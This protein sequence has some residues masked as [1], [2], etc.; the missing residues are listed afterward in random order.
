MI[1]MNIKPYKFLCDS[2]V[3]CSIW[4]KPYNY[5]GCWIASVTENVQFFWI[6]IY[7]HWIINVTGHMWQS[8]P[9]LPCMIVGSSVLRKRKFTKFCRCTIICNKVW[10]L[11]EI[12]K[13][14]FDNTENC[15]GN[16]EKEKHQKREIR[17]ARREYYRCRSAALRADEVA[18][19][20]SDISIF[21]RYVLILITA[22]LIFSMYGWSKYSIIAHTMCTLENSVDSI[23]I[24]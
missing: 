16:E 2:K 18:A 24:H 10:V 20:T 12:E 4:N 5:Y 15:I 14:C 1:K 8:F 21:T 13:H 9:E 7:S 3:L 17:L 22:Q 19:T 6:A 23:A 11:K